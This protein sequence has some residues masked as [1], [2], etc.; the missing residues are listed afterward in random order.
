MLGPEERAG[1]RVL[2]A[3]LGWVRALRVGLSV[4]L[5]AVRGAPFGDLP[6]ASDPKE[7]GSRGQVGP[8]VLLFRAL[9]RHV[10]GDDALRITGRAVEEGALTFLGR[11][12]GRLDRDALDRMD[13]AGRDAW[14][15]DK[16]DAFPNA[17]VEWK[18]VG[19][20]KVVFEVT[21]CR[22]VQLLAHAGHPE[23]GP[24]FCAGDARYFG[25]VEPGT[26]LVRPTTIAEGSDRCR[27]TIQAEGDA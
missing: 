12:L 26:E 8:A 10:G 7:R 6:P 27:F 22:F 3:E 17:T 13:D 14:A 16:A 24:L 23:L 2:V 21:A 15:R 9:G 5:A 25:E 20:R 11:T 1:L 4:Q 18:E 19:A